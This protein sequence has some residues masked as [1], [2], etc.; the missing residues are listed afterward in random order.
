MGI[1]K[2]DLIEGVV[3]GMAVL[4]CFDTS[5]Q[6]L[7]AT[8][9]AQRAGITRAA[10]RRHLL[11]LAHL[12]YLESAD[13]YYWLSSKVLRFSGSYLA[14]AR[15]PRAVQPVLD[16]LAAQTQEAFAAAVLDG[17][18]AVIVSRSGNEGSGTP[19]STRRLLAHG[20]HLGA[21]LPAHATSSGRVLLAG[22]PRTELSAWLKERQFRRLTPQTVTSNSALRAI[23]NEVRKQDYSLVYEEHET[24][25]GAL[26]VPVRDAQGNVVAALNVVVSP[27]RYGPEALLRTMF[28]PMCDAAAMLRSVL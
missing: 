2:I 16:Q 6:R 23:L 11:T 8:L 4:E 1:A 3:K 21:R 9:T 18:E 12:G 24:G 19:G 14:S 5:R 28:G 17:D 27:Q 25:V 7:N 26:A 13:G 20:L 10:A 15:V 22:L